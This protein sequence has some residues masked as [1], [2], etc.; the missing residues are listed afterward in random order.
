VFGAFVVGVCAHRIVGWRAASCMRTDLV[1]HALEQVLWSRGRPQCSL[2]HSDRGSRSLWIPYTG[3]LAEA[4]VESAVGS[5]VGSYDK[6]L[7]GTIIRPFGAEVIRRQASKRTLA[8]C[9]YATLEWVARFNRP[10]CRKRPATLRGRCWRGR[11]K[12]KRTSGYGGLTQ[13]AASPEQPGR[14]SP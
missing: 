6:A 5:R 4:G 8:A 3:R 12:G 9:E 1:P 14:L 2:H 10:G 11:T 7:A 13:P